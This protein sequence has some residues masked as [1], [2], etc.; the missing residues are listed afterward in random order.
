MTH[1]PNPLD[2]MRILVLD[3]HRELIELIRDVLHDAGAEVTPVLDNTTAARRILSD[4]YDA[5]IV[6]ASSPGSRGRDL[7]QWL[8][9]R[10][11]QILPHT[12][13][14]RDRRHDG[15]ASVPLGAVRLP[16]LF[17]PFRIDRL[18]E[19]MARMHATPGDELKT[20]G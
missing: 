1:E 13:V 7:L 19:A 11:S 20:A 3:E 6:G 10:R 5:I 9:I 18:V 14:L 4:S 16:A 15:S 17:K 12:L 8:L 2:G